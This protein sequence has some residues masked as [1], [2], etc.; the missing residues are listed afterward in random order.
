MPSRQCAVAR[1]AQVAQVAQVARASV[2]CLFRGI[3]VLDDACRK[4]QIG[5]LRL[6]A[7]NLSGHSAGLRRR[8]K[9]MSAVLSRKYHWILKTVEARK[10][11]SHEQTWIINAIV[12]A[13]SEV[14]FPKFVQ[15]LIER[16]KNDPAATM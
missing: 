6:S 4:P 15:D 12:A 14:D 7:Q 9:N 3:Y 11:A 1:V 13:E 10:L 8:E 5:G 16:T 2:S